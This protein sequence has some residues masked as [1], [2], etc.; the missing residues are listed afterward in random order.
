[1]A[2]VPLRTSTRVGV[3]LTALIGLFYALSVAFWM[4]W[5]PRPPKGTPLAPAPGRS[6]GAFAWGGAIG[7]GFR[8]FWLDQ[9]TFSFGLAS[10]GSVRFLPLF[11]GNGYPGMGPG[12]WDLFVPVWIPFIVV[13][14]PAWLLERRDR[15]RVAAEA[16]PNCEYPTIG[17]RIDDRCPEC[18]SGNATM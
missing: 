17:L 6:Y 1:M 12:W 8:P 5:D 15:R 13:A 14:A 9:P 4:R 3:A 7:V 18:G 10:E 11:R 2:R 16:C